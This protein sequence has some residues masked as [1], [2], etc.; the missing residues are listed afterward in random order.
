MNAYVKHIKV[1]RK[2]FG[3]KRKAYDMKTRRAHEEASTL[4][5]DE[6][7]KKKRPTKANWKLKSQ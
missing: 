2:V 5:T 3:M 1:C 6:P 7:K 4:A